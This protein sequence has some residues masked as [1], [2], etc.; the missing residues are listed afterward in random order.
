M[1]VLTPALCLL[2]DILLASGWTTPTKRKKDAETSET[3]SASVKKPKTPRT[4]SKTSATLVTPSSPTTRRSRRRRASD[5]AVVEPLNDEHPRKDGP[6]DNDPRNGKKSRNDADLDSKPTTLDQY[7]I[8]DTTNLFITGRD[9]LAI[10]DEV[11]G[12]QTLVLWKGSTH[13]TDHG[14]APLERVHHWVIP[15]HKGDEVQNV[16]AFMEEHKDVLQNERLLEN[17]KDEASH[18]ADNDDDATVPVETSRRWYEISV[19]RSM[20]KG[21]LAVKLIQGTVQG[22]DIV[23]IKDMKDEGV[24]WLS[25]PISASQKDTVSLNHVVQLL[26]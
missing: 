16:A 1:H 15:S 17:E 10:I 5:A 3:P 25:K 7:L 13:L 12:P 6:S 9:L 18:D 21:A 20:G 19:S 23:P 22:K 24:F 11:P 4:V 8:S 14:R 2:T 26:H